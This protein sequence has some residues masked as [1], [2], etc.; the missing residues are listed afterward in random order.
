MLPL[1]PYDENLLAKLIEQ[2]S[3]GIELFQSSE[4]SIEYR[5]I[6]PDVSISISH[7]RGERI[8]KIE[9]LDGFT[10]EIDQLR[11]EFDIAVPV[12]LSAI[13]IRIAI[14]FYAMRQVP[15][16]LCLEFSDLPQ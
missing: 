4:H 15:H 6:D 1:K 8:T 9:V 12:A 14:M 2:L 3:K 10:I 7:S 11:D 16:K 5:Y 13:A